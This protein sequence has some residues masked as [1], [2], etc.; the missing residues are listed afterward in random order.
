M[1]GNQCSFPFRF[2]GVLR[3]ACV[4]SPSGSSW[5]SIK[6]DKNS[7]HIIGDENWDICDPSCPISSEEVITS[8]TKQSKFSFYQNLI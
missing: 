8:K 1:K 6:T 2:D 5:C 4:P 7:N 3:N